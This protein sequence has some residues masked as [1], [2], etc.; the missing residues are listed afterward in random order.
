MRSHTTAW[1]DRRPRSGAS[2]AG[3]FGRLAVALLSL[4]ESVH[5]A[6]LDFSR[7]VRPIL[8]DNCFLCHGQDE[9]T[10]AS[11]LR[12]DV[13]AGLKSTIDGQPVAAAGDPAKSLLYQRVTATDPD[14][15][16]PP[17][18]SK[19]SL[20]PQQIETIRRWI[21]AGAEYREHWSLRPLIA[22][23]P[24]Q[25]S[26]AKG[27]VH[28]ID[29]FVHARL[30]QE[31]L[32]PSPEAERFRL[33]RR[34]SLDLTGLPPTPEE[35]AA[36]AADES[37]GAYERV[38]DRLLASPHYGERMAWDWLDAA[39]YA[40]SNGYQGDGERTMWPWRDWVVSAFNRNLPFDD[41]TVWQLAGDQLP[42]A[43]FEQR[44]A[45]G[46]CRN[47][48]INGE[49]GRIAEEN[50]VDYVMDMT[51]TMGTV[52]LGLTLNCCRCHD[53][54]FDPLTRRDYFALTAYFNQTPVNG[55]GG[56][57]QTPPVLAVYSP[58]QEQTLS[59]LEESLAGIQRELSERA[60]SLAVDQPAWE[61]ERR[62]ELESQRW[63]PLTPTEARANRALLEM[64]PD[65]SVLAKGP[66]DNND[67]Y[68]V[69]LKVPAGP[70]AALR[71][72]ALQH[73]SLK[74]GGLSRAESGNFVLTNLSAEWRATDAAQSLTFADAR[75]TFE[76]GE[77]TARSAIDTDPQ[78]GWAVWEGRTVDREHAAVFV[79]DKPVEFP[80]GATLE[81]RLRHDSPHAQ[82]N[83]GRFRLSVHADPAAPAAVGDVE[84][85]VALQ[86]EPQ[87]REK[88]Q[89]AL[90][91]ERH[92]ATDP[93]Y[94]R[95]AGERDR[96]QAERKSIDDAAPKVMVMQDQPEPRKT[97]LL[98]RG[99]YN[100]PRD[101]VTANVP[102]SLT[103]LPMDAPPNRLSLARWLVADE[104]PLT[105]RVTV[106]RF[107]QQFFGIG[108][109]NTPE[110]F[111]AQGEFPEHA[112]L[113]NWLAA[114]FRDHGWD[115]KRLVRQ[116][117]TSR[118]YR[119]SSRVTAAL[120][121]RDPQNRLLA[122]G[123]RYRLPSWMLRDQALAASGL[124][125][126]QLGGP[127]VKGYQPE[128]VWEEATFGNKKYTQ[129]HGAALYRR[130]LYTFWRRIIGPTMIF[131][132]AARQV[133]TVKVFRTNTPL[134]ALL[135]LNDVTYVEAARAMAQR[136]MQTNAASD[137]ERLA[138]VFGR[139][140][141]RQPTTEETTLLLA[142]LSRSRAEFESQ[143]T[144]AR[145]LLAI[146]ESPRDAALPATEHAAWTALCLAVLNL[147]EV[148][149]KE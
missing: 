99:L 149:T 58:E 113:L 38:V 43:T 137:A 57:P 77:H 2:A 33:L 17:A 83:L 146:G 36:F 145:E 100:E 20:T 74:G 87:A 76:Q 14:L 131:D 5:A 98:D 147:D 103:A 56:N 132:N 134:Q 62:A 19:K 15:R 9:G 21:E 6:D 97:F 82:H 10:R 126:P 143:P 42:D 7:D 55:G 35:V 114:D 128:G 67:V 129:D 18:D 49:G 130:S 120:H 45:T 122:R 116:I 39:R 110:D 63:Q 4:L 8:S 50:R 95:L 142:G 46:F 107:W 127:P 133:C 65:G 78:T 25:V 108:L 34:A 123:P 52:W 22:P 37:D 24:P 68:T 118:T 60:Q 106:N 124:L 32:A 84:L 148:V 105:A 104:H 139:V 140:L 80:E 144:A 102:A 70:I 94:A 101:E 54:K 64:L 26:R 71:L 112:A 41:F 90:I 115:V 89:R 136:T 47:H 91:R 61:A 135:T 119:Q 85:L 51:E 96:L 1:H 117:V 86:T 92:L 40:D 11:E 73:A 69:I 93:E 12:L 16:M 109:V 48:M 72:E 66:N 3:A 88:S 31:G 23:E 141:S 44:L 13:E 138:H 121:E 59:K 111:G 29:A 75:A 125:V 27:E 28:P 30:D 81:V 53:H 79:L